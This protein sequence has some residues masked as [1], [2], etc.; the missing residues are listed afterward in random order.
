MIKQNDKVNQTGYFYN[1]VDLPTLTNLWCQ[2]DSD[3]KN[4]LSTAFT[5]LVNNKQP[6]LQPVMDFWDQLEPDQQNVLAQAYQNLTS[7]YPKDSNLAIES[8]ITPKPKS[9]LLTFF[10]H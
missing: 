6:E 7:T 4:V 10:H 5:D 1:K 3:Q 8:P 9:R 2:F